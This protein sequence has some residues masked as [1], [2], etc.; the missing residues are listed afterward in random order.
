MSGSRKGKGRARADK[1][2]EGYYK[3][4]PSKLQIAMVDAEL[5]RGKPDYWF[6]LQCE[7]RAPM[8]SLKAAFRH[9]TKRVHTDHNR[10]ECAQLV[11]KILLEAKRSILASRR[12]KSEYAHELNERQR[13]QEP[14]EKQRLLCASECIRGAVLHWYEQDAA[15]KYVTRRVKAMMAE[16][17]VRR[18]ERLCKAKIAADAASGVY[19]RMVFREF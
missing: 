6:W 14:E 2:P 13:D 18:N 8:S 1:E 4:E 9:Y 19:A 3:G 10:H 5:S 15:D 7:R 17:E 12:A 16:A 11:T